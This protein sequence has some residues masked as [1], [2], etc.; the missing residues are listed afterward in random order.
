MART[1]VCYD[2]GIAFS[3]FRRRHHCRLCGQIFCFECSGQFIDGRAHGHKGDIRVCK[4]CA[5]F[6]EEVE[7]KKALGNAQRR[8]SLSRGSSIGVALTLPDG[9]SPDQ[10]T[11]SPLLCIPTTSLAA[12]TAG[13]LSR[14]NSVLSSFDSFDSSSMTN[15]FLD[16]PPTPS[17]GDRLAALPPLFT[18]Q[19]SESMDVDDEL[20]D[21]LVQKSFRPR[22]PHPRRRRSSVELLGAIESGG[23][24]ESDLQ[25]LKAAAQGGGDLSTAR[26]SFTTDAP[27]SFRMKSDVRTQRE[28]GLGKYMVR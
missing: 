26:A 8:T 17:D 13:G 21:R 11:V 3:L 22:P 24:L 16:S 10:D 15:S 4:F 5:R 25:Q 28:I 7:R 6:V 19:S 14:N 20:G 1:Q 2:C 12:D 23:L 9:Q 18:I 27:V